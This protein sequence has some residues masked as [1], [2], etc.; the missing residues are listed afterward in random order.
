MQAYRHLKYW[1]YVALDKFRCPRGCISVDQLVAGA[2]RD[3]DDRRYIREARRLA[4][5]SAE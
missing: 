3:S 2:E 4:G 1:Y 5:L